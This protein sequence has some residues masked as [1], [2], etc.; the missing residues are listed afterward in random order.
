MDEK[1][2]DPKKLNKLNN[3][4]RLFDIPPAYIGQKLNMHNAQVL[5][6]IG[7]GTGFFSIPFVQYTHNGK[8]YAADIS[9]VMIQWM[10][11]NIV[12]K[13]PNIVPLKM[14]E[15]VVPLKKSVADIVYMIL[16]HHELDNPENILKESF[17]LLKE[18][19]KIGIVDWVKKEM[20]Q[21]PPMHI[22]CVPEDIKTQLMRVGFTQ[23]EIDYN[24]SDNFFLIIAEK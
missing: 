21:G 16:L 1:L 13:Y 8:V 18:H 14:E 20:P 23:V 3:P 24:M 22:R 9:E 6:D 10:E 12:K 17:R 15:N 7:A 11:E 2:F 4:Q 5:I 19:G